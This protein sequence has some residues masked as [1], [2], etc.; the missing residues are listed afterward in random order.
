MGGR[1]CRR[2]NPAAVFAGWLGP[3]EWAVRPATFCWRRGRESNP[4]MEVLQTSALPLG[5]PA[6]CAVPRIVMRSGPLSMRCVRVGGVLMKR[7]GNPTF[8]IPPQPRRLGPGVGPRA[9]SDPPD[10]PRAPR[11]CPRSDA[12]NAR[13]RGNP[14]FL[15]VVDRSVNFRLPP[16][17]LVLRSTTY[18]PL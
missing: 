3:P 2:G 17:C 18:I 1:R 14:T 16:A 12:E 4:P 9:E 5:Y 10:P 15:I 13:P 11:K 8:R 7:N 6:A